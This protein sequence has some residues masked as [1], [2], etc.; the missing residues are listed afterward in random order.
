V[1][2]ASWASYT[3]PF[4][5][6]GQPAASVPCGFTGSGLPVGLQIVGGRYREDLVLKAAAAFEEARPWAESRPSI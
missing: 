4:N 2:P 1:T 5:F 3:F 6:S